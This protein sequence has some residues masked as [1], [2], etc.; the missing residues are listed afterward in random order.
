MAKE[1][2]RSNREINKPRATKPPVKTM[3]ASEIGAK[4][5]L[6]RIMPGKKEH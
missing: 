3:P 4:A 1:Q 2:K 5:T 6:D